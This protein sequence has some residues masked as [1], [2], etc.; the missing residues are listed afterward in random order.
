MLILA[1]KQGSFTLVTNHNRKQTAMRSFPARQDMQPNELSDRSFAVDERPW[2]AVD[3]MAG[4]IVLRLCDVM[5]KNFQW[6]LS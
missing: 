5:A 3:S 2:R 4:G 1:H 6:E